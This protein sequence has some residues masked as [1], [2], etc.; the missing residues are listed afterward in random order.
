MSWWYIA[1]AAV[2]LVL[3]AVVLVRR[4]RRTRVRLVPVQ[5]SADPVAAQQLDEQ[6]AALLRHR[7]SLISRLMVAEISDDAGMNDSVM[8]EIGRMV[9]E[10]D[11]FMRQNRLL[12]DRWQPEMIA[13]FRSCGLDDAEIEVCCLYAMGLN[14]KTIQQYTRDGRHYQNVGLIRKKLGLGEHDKNIDGYIRSLM[15]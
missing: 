6:L 2:V 3:V 14:G 7:A 8:E 11:E 15:K 9:A 13:H 10:K 5:P 4:R 1:V 12:F